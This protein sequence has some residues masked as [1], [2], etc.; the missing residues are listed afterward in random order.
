MCAVLSMW[1]SE[2]FGSSFRQFS[3]MKSIRWLGEGL[4][5]YLAGRYFL[6]LP[7]KEVK[8]KAVSDSNREEGT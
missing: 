5:V 6:S 4:C 2:F 1:I 8:S 7:T 3:K